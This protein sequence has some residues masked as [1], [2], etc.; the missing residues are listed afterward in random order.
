MFYPCVP[1]PTSEKNAVLGIAY[2][3][4]GLMSIYPEPVSREK[5]WIWIHNTDLISVVK[6][7]KRV[8]KLN[9]NEIK[10]PVNLEHKP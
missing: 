8:C 3:Q 5:M 4:I 9:T 1:D 6:D 7:F 2:Y 10:L